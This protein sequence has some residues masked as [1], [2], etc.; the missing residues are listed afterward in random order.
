[1][2]PFPPPRPPS[3]AT[4]E[5]A[6]VT[7][8]GPPPP[9]TPS[10]ASASVEG[11]PLCLLEQSSHTHLALKRPHAFKPKAS[12]ALIPNPFLQERR[13][14]LNHTEPLAQ[15]LRP[16]VLSQRREPT[17]QATFFFIIIMFISF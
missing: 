4:P 5:V 3:P 17:S 10:S 6:Q 11:V 7:I 2:S 15:G 9:T 14:A 8:S 12:S 13:Q 16:P 1:M